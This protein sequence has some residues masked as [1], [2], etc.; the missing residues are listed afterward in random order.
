MT[1]PM[2]RVGP[3]EVLG[4]LG[5][6]GAG[7]V[8]RARDPAGREVALKVLLPGAAPHARKRFLR[9]AR[10]LARVRHPGVVGVVDVSDDDDRPWIAMELVA[11]ETLEARLAREGPLAPRAAA[12][13]AERLAEAVAHV[14][15]AGVLHRDINPRNVIL[16]A[17]GGE[18]VLA[19]LGL[20]RDV[21][22]TSQSRVSIEGLFLGSPGYWP[23]EQA[24]GDVDRIGVTA[25]VYGLGATLFAALTGRP[26]FLVGSLDDALRCLDED[27]PPPSRLRP[28]VDPA[29]DALV[30][31][32][33]ARAPGARF[34]RRR[35]SA[36]R[37][38]GC[39]AA[40]A[41]GGRAARSPGSWPAARRWRSSGSWP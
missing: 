20:T 12:R 22:P 38:A 4:E 8:L 29:L 26:P 21:A 3:F 5:R 11:G 34:P 14:H 9:E 32:C 23:P 35:R 10:A 6:G 28:E 36:R 13:L 7:A 40:A 25:D 37:S 30:L 15:G 2:S 33:L 39:G 16:R 17:A 27:P 41:A 18:P 31:R 19:D 1:R 24:R